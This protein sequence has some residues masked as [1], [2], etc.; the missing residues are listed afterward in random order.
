MHTWIYKGK[1]KQ[2]TYLY[3][4]DS[5]DFERVPETLL[6]LLGEL[7]YVVDIE[8]DKKKKLA[9]ADTGEVISQLQS[10]G[11]YLQLPPGDPAPEKVC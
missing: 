10:N 4:T 3:I 5:E 9:Q 7:S 11:Y 8:L 6:R 1:H 2:D